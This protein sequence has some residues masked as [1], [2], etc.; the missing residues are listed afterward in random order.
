MIKDCTKLLEIL[1]SCPIFYFM[2]L[3]F[4]PFLQWWYQDEAF[5]DDF[6]QPLEQYYRSRRS[7][8]FSLDKTIADF[9]SDSTFNVR[10]SSDSGHSRKLGFPFSTLI[11]L[12][13]EI[14][15]NQI[16]I[17]FLFWLFLCR[18]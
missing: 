9:C 13:D 4:F 17:Q 8:D 16:C 6:V 3:L 2:I 11:I 18:Q 1:R 12:E 7:L 10:N 15:E 5:S 14:Y